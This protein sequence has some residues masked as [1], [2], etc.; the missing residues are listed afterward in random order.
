[1]NM[2]QR[3]RV[4][5]QVVEMIFRSLMIDFKKDTPGRTGRLFQKTP[6][7]RKKEVEHKWTHSMAKGK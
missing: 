7:V 2:S 6:K 5:S 4:R 3:I 1:M